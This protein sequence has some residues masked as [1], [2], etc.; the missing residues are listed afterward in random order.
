MK[1]INIVS[2]YDDTLEAAKCHTN[3]SITTPLFQLASE[4][5]IVS[6]W[7]EKSTVDRMFFSFDAF[8]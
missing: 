3:K 7:I 5:Q 2:L 8:L 4:V 6:I 1:H